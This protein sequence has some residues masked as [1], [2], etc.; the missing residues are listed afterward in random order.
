VYCIKIINIS[1]K[2]KGNYSGSEELRE[3]IKIRKPKVHLF[4][5]IHEQ[6]GVAKDHHHGTLFV[7]SA[8]KNRWGE[9]RLEHHPHL[10]VAKREN[11]E[12]TFST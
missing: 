6:Y 4:G 7:N 9:H 5:H 8:M 12:W 3:V 11:N 1:C 2:P 10:I